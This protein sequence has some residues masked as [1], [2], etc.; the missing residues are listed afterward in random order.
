MEFI[1]IDDLFNHKLLVECF[2]F[3][4]RR[5]KLMCLSEPEREPEPEWNT[6]RQTGR[7]RARQRDRVGGGG[8]EN[9]RL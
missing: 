5:K 4:T 7:Q 2:V 8:G 3:S 9:K 1:S 6:E